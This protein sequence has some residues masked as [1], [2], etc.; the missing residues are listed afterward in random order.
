MLLISHGIVAN[1]EDFVETCPCHRKSERLTDKRVKMFCYRSGELDFLWRASHRGR[2]GKC[3]MKG[4]LV[5]EK[6]T[7]KFDELIKEFQ[8][9]AHQEVMFVCHK[10]SPGDRASVLLDF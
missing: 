7:G 1:L 5:P 6:A 8:T 10:L 9:L 3:H 2:F 4:R